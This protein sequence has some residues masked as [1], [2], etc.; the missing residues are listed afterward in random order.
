M[1]YLLSV[2]AFLALSPVI[3]CA[4]DPDVLRISEDTYM[5]TR[6]SFAGMF[7]NMSRMKSR[8]INQA[9]EFAESQGKVAIPISERQRR[10]NPGFPSYEY[11]FRL[12]DADNPGA[13][14]AALEAG[15]D[16]V[17][18]SNQNIDADVRI[19]NDSDAETDLYT[20]LLKLDDLRKRGILTDDE[21]EEL[22]GK[23]LSEN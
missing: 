2:L 15:P 1:K 3:V 7:A 8:V 11:Q 18:Q 22:K 9:N 21:F 16:A 20:E 4:A 14:S 17:V 12:V 13:Q 23:L 6:T 10:P 5:I 19:E